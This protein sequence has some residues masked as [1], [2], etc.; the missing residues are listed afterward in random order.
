MKPEGSGEMI[1][2]DWHN[3]LRDPWS[4]RRKREHH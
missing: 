2:C 1:G 3:L 4:T